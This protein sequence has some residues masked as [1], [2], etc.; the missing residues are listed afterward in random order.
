MS[1]VKSLKVK[2][3]DRCPCG[4]G[5]KYKVCCKEGVISEAERQKKKEHDELIQHRIDNLIGIDAHFWVVREG[6][7][8]DTDF[9]V[10]NKIRQINGCDERVAYCPAPK[11]IQDRY[12]ASL[13]RKHLKGKTAE[14]YKTYT[15]RPYECVKNSAVEY[16]RNGG[17]IVFGSMGFFKKG[18]QEIWWEFGGRHYDTPEMFINQM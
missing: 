2:P 6:K 8:I 17:E 9:G 10:Y 3:N 13:T 12:I 15:P 11:H 5:K 14:D 18:S 7:V 16:L 1:A 4:S